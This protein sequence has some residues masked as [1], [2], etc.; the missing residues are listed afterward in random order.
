MQVPYNSLEERSDNLLSPY[1]GSSKW[2]V[3][4]IYKAQRKDYVDEWDLK[5]RLTR[6]CIQFGVHLV[7]YG[8]HNDGKYKQLHIHAIVQ[9][10]GSMEPNYNHKG[11]SY[12]LRPYYSRSKYKEGC[13][14][15]RY[16][17]RCDWACP[18]KKEQ[19]M[20]ENYYQYNYHN[21]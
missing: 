11:W 8:F 14:Y 3:L 9:M 13:P 7:D 6:Y 17:H 10:V 2:Y 19:L 15:W 21:F 4:T 1:Y 20:L 16:I 5:A 12:V 18:Y